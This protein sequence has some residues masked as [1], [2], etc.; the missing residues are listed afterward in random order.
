MG[1]RGR[2]RTECVVRPNTRPGRDSWLERPWLGS[3]GLSGGWAHG[4]RGRVANYGRGAA[5]A[6]RHPFSG[7]SPIAGRQGRRP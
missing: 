5:V 2:G 7:V 1:Q 6:P 3:W 4:V